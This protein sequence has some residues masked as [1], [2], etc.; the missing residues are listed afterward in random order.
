MLTGKTLKYDE[1]YRPISVDGM[2]HSGAVNDLIRKCIV[3]SREDRWQ[4]IG[5]LEAAL[6]QIA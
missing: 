2:M 3:R 1:A 5:A 4:G 6:M